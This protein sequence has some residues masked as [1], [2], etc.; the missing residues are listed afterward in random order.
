MPKAHYH[1]KSLGQ[2]FLHD[3]YVIDQIIAIINPKATDSLI[4][5][6]PGQGAITEHLLETC[7]DLTLIEL[8]DRLIPALQQLCQPH[9]NHRVLHDNV[10]NIDFSQLC[11]S[12]NGPLRIVGNLPYNIST[13]LMLKLCQFHNLVQDIT[14]MVQQEVAAR[15]VAMPNCKQYGRLSIMLQAYFEC[16]RLLEVG[17][18]AF[19]PPPKVN[20]TI[21]WLS[22]KRPPLISSQEHDSF[23]NLLRQAFQT[24]RKTIANNLKKII[25]RSDLEKLG[26]DPNLRPENISGTQ[27]DLL[28]KHLN[29]TTKK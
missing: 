17:P 5:I 16:H 8:D 19:D 9:S 29:S 28:N 14:V 2:N 4:E 20:S 18:Q 15:I 12:A 21:L 6:G 11:S 13:P 27:Y 3:P 22:P 1:K 10:L 26:I 25:N 24:R 23:E 7:Q